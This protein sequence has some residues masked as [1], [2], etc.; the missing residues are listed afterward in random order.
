MLTDNY[1]RRIDYLRVSVTDQCDL[2]CLYCRPR[3]LPLPRRSYPRDGELLS[4]DQILTVVQA[5]ARLGVRKVRLTGGEPLLR[6]GIVDLVQSIAQTPGIVDIGLTTNAMRLAQM[7]EDLAAAGLK[8]VNISLDTLQPK[9]FPRIAGAGTLEMAWRGIEAAQQAN[10]WPLKLNTVVMKDIND[11][12][13]EDFAAMTVKHDWH[14]RF[15]EVMPI[16]GVAG[17][18]LLVT[19][20][21]MQAR[22][23][24][25]VPVEDESGHAAARVYRWPDARGTIG[26]ISPVSDHFCAGCNRLRLTADGRLRP[27]LLSDGEVDLRP[28]LAEGAGSESL[29]IL[30]RQAVANKPRQHRLAEG[31]LPAQRTMTQIGG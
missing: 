11:D 3:H 1:D 5:A 20:A 8:R 21:E 12:E 10:L 24:G 7:A 16:G 25:L 27:C 13:L 23:P 15:I 19:A 26:F 29:D 30:I 22:L 17:Q 18:D 9:R 28:A 6:H 2:R 4:N 31:I 14:V